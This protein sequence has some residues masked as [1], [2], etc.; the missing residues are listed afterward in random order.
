[1]HKK[2]LNTSWDIPEKEE[3]TDTKEHDTQC[4]WQSGSRRPQR[5][6]QGRKKIKKRGTEFPRQIRKLRQDLEAIRA[7]IIRANPLSKTKSR[8]I[9]RWR[10]R[11]RQLL[12]VM[13][14]PAGTTILSPYKKMN[15]KWFTGRIPSHRMLWQR[16]NP[17]KNGS[18]S[19]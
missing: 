19:V 15:E 8:K 5:F 11:T 7:I 17:H 18:F 14:A 4:N 12:S 9:P 16:T 13:R 3:E 1:M 2:H 6:T 10:V